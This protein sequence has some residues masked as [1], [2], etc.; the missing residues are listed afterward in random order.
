MCL[1]KKKNFKM[2]RERSNMKEKFYEK[3]AWIIF[4][5]IGILI[6]AAGILHMSG[7]NT[8]PTMVKFISGQAIGELQSSNP[9]FFDL[10]RFYFTGGGLSDVG[11]AFFLIVITLTAYRK[12]LKWSWYALWFVPV[13]FL[14]W[15]L[16]CLNLPAEAK[17]SLFPSLIFFIVLSFA[18]LLLPM[19]K[20]FAKRKS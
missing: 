6:M 16:I 11:F 9:E 4:L 8:D 14:T 19:K 17:F 3:Y 5:V 18:G 2:K 1:N 20:F 13:F 12:G 15:I 7:I 10:Y